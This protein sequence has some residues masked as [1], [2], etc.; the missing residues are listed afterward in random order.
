MILFPFTF[1]L[2]LRGANGR[3]WPGIVVIDPD[4]EQPGA[5]WAQEAYE[6]LHKLNPINLLRVRLSRAAR[7]DMEIMGH[8]IEVQAAALF[9]GADLVSR[10]RQEA[11]TMHAGYDGLFSGVSPE[12][13]AFAMRWKSSQ[14][15]AWVERNSRR[16]EAFIDRS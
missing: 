4:A 9:Y 5:V 2:R 3:N 16:I 12:R 11:A 1:V 14:A 6:A 15:T 10:R 8:E 7:R 13:I